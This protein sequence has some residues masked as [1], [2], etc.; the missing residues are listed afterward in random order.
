M[1]DALVL[2]LA[3]FDVSN[4]KINVAGLKHVAAFGFL[5][6]QDERKKVQGLTTG[7]VARVSGGRGAA[8]GA[9]QAVAISSSSPGGPVATVGKKKRASD[10]AVLRSSTKAL[11]NHRVRGW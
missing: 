4:D 11:F 7:I 5:L 2:G 1:R 9:S 8:P 3:K 10:E 6:H